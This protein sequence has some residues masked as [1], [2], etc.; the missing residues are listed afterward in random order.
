MWQKKGSLTVEAALVIPVFVYTV[1]FFLYFINIIIVQENIQFTIT[2]VGKYAAKYAY[3]Y[4]YIKNDEVDDSLKVDF[5]KQR[6]DEDTIVEKLI[7]STIDSTLLKNKMREFIDEDKINNSCIVNG[8]A[9]LDLSNSKFMRGIEGVDFVVVYKIRLPLV[10]F[11]I[12]DIYMVQRVKLRGWT[13]Y[14]P[15]SEH[16]TNDSKEDG[17]NTDIDIVYIAE[18]G[19]VYHLSNNCTH[20]KLSIHKVD[21]AQIEKLRNTSGGKYKECELC[22]KGSSYIEGGN[23]YTTDTGDRYHRLV[24]CNGLKRSIREVLLT[25]VGERTL[26]K[27]CETNSNK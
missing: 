17:Q 22:I 18:T 13:G 23:V 27:R 5:N 8:F 1:I 7:A 12:K 20:L 21:F 26:C 16:N 14:K 15:V 9:G 10:F 19:S 11:S 25:A 2:E 3:V 4:D 6:E 24:G